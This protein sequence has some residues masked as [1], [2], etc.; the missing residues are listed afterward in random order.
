MTK[1]NKCP[2]DADAYWEHRGNGRLEPL[3]ALHYMRRARWVV[4]LGEWLRE[5]VG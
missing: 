4:G 2:R 5:V 3:C 1:C